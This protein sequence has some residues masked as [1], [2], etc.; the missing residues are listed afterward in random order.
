[1]LASLKT[2]TLGSQDFRGAQGTQ[3]L[4][5]AYQQLLLTPQTPFPI[6][7]QEHDPQR[8]GSHPTVPS[9]SALCA[10]VVIFFTA[11]LIQHW[12]GGIIKPGIW[13][14]LGKLEQCQE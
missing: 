11:F 1:M 2:F 6:S 7:H 8:L 12:T 4:P 5:I 9:L 14:S 10:P 3:V 13:K